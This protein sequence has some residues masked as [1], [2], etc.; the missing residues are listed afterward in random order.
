MKVLL[1]DQIAVVNYK[2]SY[3]LANALN[4]CGND[5]E[6]IIDD[7]SENDYLICKYY[8]CFLTSRKDIGKISKLINYVKSYK[9]I[10]KKA[11]QEK[12]DIVHVQWFQ[13]SPVDY[14][15]LKKLKKYGIK[16]IITVHD[17]LPFN[18]KKYDLPYHKKIYGL[19]D[20]IIVQ[21]ETNIKRFDELFP[22]DSSK[23]HF[24]P[25][26]HFLDFADIHD[27]AEARKHLGIPDDKFV[28][29]FFGQIKK[30]KGVGVLLEAFGKLIQE[31]NDVFLVIAGNV[32]KDDFSPYQEIIDKYNLNDNVLKKDIRFIP[33]EEVGYYYSACDVS[34]LPYLDVY[35]S[36]V[37]QLTYAYN[38]PAVATKIA[39]FKE[40][41]K[42]N[43]SGIMCQPNN[44]IELKNALDCAYQNMNNLN[45]MGIEGRNTII[46]KYSW[47]K[48]A[49]K[50]NV[51]YEM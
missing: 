14:F 45:S 22:E 44:V 28:Y 49:Q 25:H 26:G 10:V 16:L 27:K 29:L 40:V 30:V 51:L 50:I 2:Y 4:K 17:I 13:F 32:W 3:S 43:V 41:V 38:K 36:G 7:K 6:M 20:H 9:F 47:E 33:D 23:V 31:R 18:Q 21:A 35:Q 5:V 19:G 12:F 42:D 15:Y 24:I 46:E 11:V 39:A 37:I 1:V 48:I 34:V 8:N